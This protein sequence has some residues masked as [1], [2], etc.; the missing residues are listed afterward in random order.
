MID[1]SN[2]KDTSR[3][4]KKVQRIGRGIGSR[5]GG[6]AGRGGKGDSHR[7][8]YRKRF[9]YEGGQVPLYRKLPIRGFT[10]G[11]F[12]KASAHISFAKI[13]QYYQDGETVN[14]ATLREK[15]LIPRRVPG[16]IKILA[17]GDLTKKVKIEAHRFSAS[18]LQRLQEQSIVHTVI[19]L[20]K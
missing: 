13:E 19:G 5:R 14:V 16:G 7:S 12:V 17:V 15:G 1:L 10:R 3:P 8:G 2:L 20:K 9:G 6:H 18:A 4:E 11:L